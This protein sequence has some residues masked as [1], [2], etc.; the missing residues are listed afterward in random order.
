MYIKE[1]SPWS[2]DY[3]NNYEDRLKELRMLSLKDRWIQFDMVQTFKIVREIDR[4]DRRVW[5]EFVGDSGERVTRLSVDPLNIK[6]NLS[7]TELRRR[8]FSNRLVQQW[9]NLQKKCPKRLSPLKV[10]IHSENSASLRIKMKETEWKNECTRLED[11]KVVSTM[12]LSV[13][14]LIQNLKKKQV[15]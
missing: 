9:D 7:N 5:F 10:N 3:S 2:P 1:L 6:S 11:L 4:V 15:E 13:G 8:F 14:R 12:S